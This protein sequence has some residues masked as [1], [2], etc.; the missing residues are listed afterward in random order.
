MFKSLIFSS[1]LFSPLLVIA[2]TNSQIPT[3]N[4]GVNYYSY[5]TSS[6]TVM[7][8]SNYRTS[9]FY[10]TN[11]RV[12]P[13]AVNIPSNLST[14]IY[15]YQQFSDRPGVMSGVTP[16]QPNNLNNLYQRN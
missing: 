3:N 16:V 11:G 1:L 13:T 7:V 4:S 15:R 10:N 14:G 6:G 12:Y 5:T 9:Q 8:P 2:Q